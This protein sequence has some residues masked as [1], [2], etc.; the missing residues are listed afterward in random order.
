VRAWSHE[1]GHRFVS[2]IRRPPAAPHPTE[3]PGTAARLPFFYGW[4]IAALAGLSCF[5]GAGLNNVSLAVLLRPL[6]EDLGGSRSLTAGA[7]GAGTIVAGLLAPVVGGLADRFGPRVLVPVGAAL[8]GGLVFAMSHVSEPWAFYA[9]YIPARALAEPTLVSVVPLTAITNWF[10]RRRP[11]VM[12]LVAMAVPLGSSVLVLWYQF[13][14]AHG[15]WRLAFESLAVLFWIGLV[16][17][18][19]LLLRRRPEDLGLAPDGRPMESAASSSEPPGAARAQAATLEPP[20]WTLRQALRTPTLWLLA[21]AN[22]LAGAATGGT[23]FNLVAYLTDAR[24]DPAIAAGALSVFALAG[25]VGSAVWGLMA[26][27]V[28]ARILNMGT[29]TGAAGAMLLLLRVDAAPLAYV[30]TAL[31]G[32]TAR[33]QGVLVQVQLAQYFGRRSYGAISGLANPFVLGGLGLGPVLAA[34]AFDL[35]GS[36]AGVFAAFGGLFLLAAALTGLARP[37]V[38]P[39]S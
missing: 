6:S 37:P 10:L 9:T 31:F 38:L 14:L 5:L 34:L 18:G 19:A 21:V 13:L 35:S 2:S 30:F 33:G 27:R 20:S 29:L 24:I 16:I 15:G 39:A 11:R 36:Y 32:L 28:P 12:G 3:A 8:A 26:E 25:A 4:I 17:P 22:G 23:A 7:I 1:E